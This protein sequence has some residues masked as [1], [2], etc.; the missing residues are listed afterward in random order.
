MAAQTAAQNIQ[1]ETQS[2]MQLKQAEVAFDIEKLKNE[3]QLK[4]MLWIKS[5]K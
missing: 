5:S 3:A 4:L 2:K 1:L